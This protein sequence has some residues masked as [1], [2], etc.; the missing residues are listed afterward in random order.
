MDKNLVR[1]ARL[2]LRVL[3]ESS[4]YELQQRAK[5]T[6]NGLAL[7]YGDIKQCSKSITS[8]PIHQ[9]VVSSDAMYKI[10]DNGSRSES[11]ATPRRVI[12]N[13]S[14]GYCPEDR[15]LIISFRTMFV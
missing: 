14:M 15:I 1:C 2:T 13:L 11:A 4:R 7:L 5:H 9:S 10:M 8:R 6:Y 3:R 12:L